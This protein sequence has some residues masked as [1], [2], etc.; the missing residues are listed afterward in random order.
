MYS[1][2]ENTPFLV[3][4]DYV[5]K[6]FGLTLDRITKEFKVKGGEQ[7]ALLSKRGGH[8]IIQLRVLLDNND[9]EPDKHCVFYNGSELVDNQKHSKVE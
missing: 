2:E 6:N 9:K 5:K 3:A 8:Y 7:L 1:T 4:Q